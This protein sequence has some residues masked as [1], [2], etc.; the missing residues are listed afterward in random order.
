MSVQQYVS[1][2]T[3]ICDFLYSNIVTDGVAFCDCLYSIMLLNYS[4]MWPNVQKF[5]TDSTAVI[6]WL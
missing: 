6:D 3:V 4:I 1:E 2:R 5:V